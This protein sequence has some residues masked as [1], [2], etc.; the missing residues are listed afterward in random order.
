MT[1]SSS[2][3]TAITGRPCPTGKLSL[4]SIGYAK[5][6]KEY[7]SLETTFRLP[8]AESI[9]QTSGFLKLAAITSN[10]SENFDEPDEHYVQLYELMEFPDRHQFQLVPK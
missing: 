10:V 5:Y 2:F 7:K 6:P 1:F 9:T 4:G 8:T 3:I